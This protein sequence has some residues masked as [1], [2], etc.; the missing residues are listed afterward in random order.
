MSRKYVVVYLKPGFDTVAAR[1]PEDAARIVKASVPYG[2]RVVAV[3]PLKDGPPTE[4]A[5]LDLPG[6]VTP[7]A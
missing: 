5:G 3:Y 6:S 7:V 2:S 1:S 4:L